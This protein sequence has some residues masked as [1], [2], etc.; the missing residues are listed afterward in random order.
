MEKK[1]PHWLRGVLLA[2]LAVGLIWVLAAIH[3]VLTLLVV[4]ALL[5]YLFDPVASRLEARGMHRAGAT[6]VVFAG[7]SL[8]IAIL[9]M[10]FFPLVAVQVKSVQSGFDGAQARAGIESLEFWLEARLAVVGVENLDLIANMQQLAVESVDN[11]LSYVP[12]VLS[13]VAQLLIVP[14]IMFFLIKD[15]RRIKK[16]FIALVPNSYFEF[17]LNVLHKTDV[18]LGNYLRGQLIASSVVALLS[19]A[20]LWFLGVDY[21]VLI[22][23]F[24]GVTNM[25]P[26]LG[27]VAGATLAVLVS[28][29]TTGSVDSVLQ[30]IA[31]F[32]II[33]LIDNVGVQPLVL[34]RKVE[35]HPLLVL[36]TLILAGK[37][38]GVIGLLLGVPVT[39]VLKVFVVETIRNLRSYRLT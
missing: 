1:T 33:Q 6:T 21:F 16:G 26:Y 24:A 3:D 2:G 15:G 14:F 37:F 17:T 27:S 4:A 32:V 29:I 28:V 20:A 5:A 22:G 10:Y 13:L 25:I 11:I 31:V 8:G 9:M 18:Q 38:F 34:A 39:A 30:I 7:V 23:L 19:M 12:G 36:L 35:L